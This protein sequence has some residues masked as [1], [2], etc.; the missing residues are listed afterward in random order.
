MR[1]IAKI[2]ALEKLSFAYESGENDEGE[3]LLSSFGASEGLTII[4]R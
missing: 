2:A 4:L 3:A 1:K